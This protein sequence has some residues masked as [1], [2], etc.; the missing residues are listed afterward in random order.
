MTNNISLESENDRNADTA[1]TD[2]ALDVSETAT[3]I[4]NVVD[5]ATDG[6]RST[7]TEAGKTYI[8]D[9][10]GRRPSNIL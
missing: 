3:I 10:R 9:G 5:G 2:K 6:V 8:Y 4:E 1:G 7:P